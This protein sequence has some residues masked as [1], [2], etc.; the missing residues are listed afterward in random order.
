ERTD[1]ESNE[2]ER[3]IKDDFDARSKAVFQAA[4]D[5]FGLLDATGHVVTLTGRLFQKTN[6]NTKL[7]TG[8]RFSET[9]FWQSSE[10]TAR[11]VDKAIV[12][13]AGGKDSNLLVD[14][15]VS[16]EEKVPIDLRFQLLTID[17]STDEIFVCGRC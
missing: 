1:P 16:A 10:N 14:F 15:R 5:F 13:V 2:S 7:L 3:V 8:Q 17:D 12:D 6:T 4:F 11:L 9:V